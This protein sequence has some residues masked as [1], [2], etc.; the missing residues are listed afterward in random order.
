VLNNVIT[1][2][3]I[4]ADAAV[5]NSYRS[6]SLLLDGNKFVS[7]PALYHWN[8]SSYTTLSSVQSTLGFEESGTA[9]A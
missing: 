8:L 3:S 9:I 4:D 2:G 5:V 6:K 7:C 1:S